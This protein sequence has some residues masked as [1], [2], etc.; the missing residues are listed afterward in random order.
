MKKTFLINFDFDSFYC[1]YLFSVKPQHRV[2]SLQS[3]R[4]VV[5]GQNAELYCRLEALPTGITYRWFKDGSQ[6]FDSGDYTINT[7]SDGQRLTANQ[8]KKS[9]AGQYSCE[10]QNALGVGERKSAYLLVNCK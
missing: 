7:I 10:G 6:I 2:D 8:V 3:K 1:L 5:E 4:T 9:S